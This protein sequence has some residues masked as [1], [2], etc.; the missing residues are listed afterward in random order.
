MEAALGQLH[1]AKP[2]PPVLRAKRGG[3][4]QL[5]LQRGGYMES[6]PRPSEHRSAFSTS[7]DHWTECGVTRR[8][9]DKPGN[10]Q[11]PVQQQKTTAEDAVRT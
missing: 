3:L 7:S 8:R 6:T 4:V 11:E 1:A 2:P 10:T 9:K 5:C